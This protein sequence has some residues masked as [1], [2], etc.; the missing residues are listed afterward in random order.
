M[1]ILSYL[2]LWPN[3]SF[4]IIIPPDSNSFSSNTTL[5]TNS[6]SASASIAAL[7]SPPVSSPSI[8]R[9]PAAATRRSSLQPTVMSQIRASSNPR[10][11]LMFSSRVDKSFREGYER[12]RVAFERRREEKAR[13]DAASA[14]RTGFLGWARAPLKELGG[15]GVGGGR[16]HMVL[17]G[18]QHARRVLGVD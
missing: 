15:I 6:T 3:P 9:P 5:N 4:N 17:S 2:H 8:P 1:S 18:L 13:Q 11:E 10:G 7:P 12:Y 16:H 14:G